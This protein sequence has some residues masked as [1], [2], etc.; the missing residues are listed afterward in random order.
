MRIQLISRDNGFG[1]TRDVSVL[2]S[3]LEPMGHEIDFTPWNSP[4]KVAKH[5]YDA[6]VFVELLSPAFLGQARMNYAFL[7]P[8]WTMP[9]WIK[10]L[11][12]IDLILAKTHDA[13]RIFKGYRP[14]KYTG[15]TSVDRLTVRQGLDSILHIQG[16]ST[17]KGTEQ[18]IEAARRLPEIEFVL[19]GK[20]LPDSVPENVVAIRG[21]QD[22]SWIRNYQN[23]ATVHC[24][25]STYEGFGH[26]INEAKSCGA[27]I[28][29]TAAEPMTDLVDPSFGYGVP[30]CS[31]QLDKHGLA[32]HK[33]PCVDGLVEA[34]R[35]AHERT[36]K[37]QL[38]A[39]ARQSYLDG[40]EQFTKRIQELF[41][42]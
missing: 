3:A 15:F 5:H 22:D 20:R 39:L 4:R 29:T 18:V 17:A 19:C 37:E 1:L 23:A 13:E 42:A 31:E 33:I 26:V 36:D 2:R 32:V 12:G 34:I 10:Y 27:V 30:H 40:K 25:P 9:G 8:E 6:N 35:H 7:N 24:Q 28:I 11:S 14:T 21:S 38:G 41:P 16:D